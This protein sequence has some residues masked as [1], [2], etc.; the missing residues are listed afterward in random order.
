MDD[1]KKEV[2]ELFDSLSRDELIE[3]LIESGFEVNENGTGKINYSE[4]DTKTS[5]V[6]ANVTSKYN[7][8]EQRN[9]QGS[10]G[11]NSFPVAC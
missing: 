1:I 10:T 6:Y 9:K 5:R 4:H 8:Q 7:T 3:L 11:I 2:K